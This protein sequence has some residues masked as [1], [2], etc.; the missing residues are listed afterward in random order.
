[1]RLWLQMN[2]GL[3]QWV[4]KLVLRGSDLDIDLGNITI[5]NTNLPMYQEEQSLE[6]G[7]AWTST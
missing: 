2:A 1:M 5:V 4:K 6:E 7:V 3:L